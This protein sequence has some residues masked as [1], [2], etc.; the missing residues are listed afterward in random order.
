MDRRN[1]DMRTQRGITLIEILLWSVVVAATVVAVFAFAKRVRVAAAVETEQRQV[2]QVVKTVNGLFALQPNFSALGEDGAAYL[3]ARGATRMG[4]KLSP[5][6]AGAPALTTGLGDGQLNLSVWH[7]TQPSGPTIANGGYRLAYQGLSANECVRLTSALAFN[8]HQASVG[9]HGLED[10]SATVVAHRY[11]KRL[12][13]ADVVANLCARPDPVVFLYFA[14]ARS[15]SAN[16]VGPVGPPSP[17]C[18]P[19]HE[20]QYAAC[21]PGQIGTVIQ[22]RDG[23]CTGPGNTL[24]WTAWSTTDSS[25]QTPT[26]ITPPITPSLPPDDCTVITTTRVQ[27]CPAGQTGQILEESARDTC[28]GTQ[29]A[30]L[31]LPPP[32]G[33][34]CQ[35][36]LVATCVPSVE[37]DEVACPAGQGGQIVRERYSTC[38]SPQAVPAWPAWSSAHVI[39]NTCT[40]NCGVS[41]TLTFGNTCCTPI[42]DER[43]AP[44]PAGTYGPG[45]KEI[46]FQGCVNAT[47]QAS[48]WSAWEPYRDL[49]PSPGC[50]ACP[51]T[52]QETEQQWDPRAETCPT[53]QTGSITYEAEQVRTRDVSYSCP[54]GTTALPSPAIGTW[55]GWADTGARRNTVNTCVATP[56]AAGCQSGQIGSDVLSAANWW[57]PGYNSSASDWALNRP[58][59]FGVD[60]IYIAT[61]ND[62]PKTT[63]DDGGGTVVTG[64]Q[65]MPKASWSTCGLPAADPMVE[66]GDYWHAT[67][68]QRLAGTPL[69][70]ECGT[71]TPPIQCD[72]PAGKVFNWTVGGNDCTFAQG[73]A[74]SVAVSSD[75]PVTDSTAPTT[76]AAVFACSAGGVLATTPNAGA[77][78]TAPVSSCYT[79]SPTNPALLTGVWRVGLNTPVNAGP[80]GGWFW[81][82]GVGFR[83]AIQHDAARVTEY[84]NA[85]GI[86]GS[87]SFQKC[88]PS[89]FGDLTV[90]N[91]VLPNRGGNQVDA[92]RT[93]WLGWNNVTYLDANGNSTNINQSGWTEI[94]LPRL[95]TPALRCVPG[96]LI[97]T[98]SWNDFGSSTHMVL[99]CVAG[100]TQC[101]V[102]A[103]ALFNWVVG[104][105]SC[106]YTQ[107]AATTVSTSTNFAVTDST[108]PTTG[109]AAF[110]CSAGGVLSMTANA[111]ATCTTTASCTPPTGLLDG[112]WTLTSTSQI[113][114]YGGAP[115]NIETNIGDLTRRNATAASLGGAGPWTTTPFMGIGCYATNNGGSGTGVRPMAPPGGNCV[116]G[117]R[118]ASR[119]RGPSAMGGAIYSPGETF[120]FTCV[121]PPPP[122]YNG[123]CS[124]VSRPLTWGCGEI[125]L[126]SGSWVH[127]PGSVNLDESINGGWFGNGTV[128]TR[129]VF[130]YSDVLDAQGY[131]TPLTAADEGKL[132]FTNTSPSADWFNDEFLNESDGSYIGYIGFTRIYARDSAPNPVRGALCRQT[133]WEM[134]NN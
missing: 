95:A 9:F 7:V 40:A 60:D 14:P 121:A 28:A 100:P 71:A 117:E 120:F 47:T 93:T 80:G 51:A 4:L 94:W 101:D 65:T 88:I 25:C 98:R 48:T 19:I 39:S 45:G 127:T 13:G 106:T 131:P 89:V 105:N 81:D 125:R 114:P 112:V 52:V 29:T 96:E 76:G 30:W 70:A 72:I 111:G 116:I 6:A 119:V 18:N 87:A 109:S 134:M 130:G 102:P 20:K 21:P 69:P 115:G 82:D 118:I 126:V 122:A 35:T 16:G 84:M 77:T 43:D 90:F 83:G 34:T 59:L 36:P 123:L 103:G 67:S 17:R 24:V 110:A 33:N 68:Y 38:A 37:H 46:R 32:I 86:G 26:T 62:D 57:C 92:A 66:V 54:A 104:G 64:W 56:P 49:E 15:I 128:G 78:C 97:V 108:T 58:A 23:T 99:E 27:A 31:Q 53:G 55:T 85:I 11:N 50:T 5:G 41:S 133:K 63:A 10:A 113:D 8:A 44:C 3:A 79:P 73:M 42:P 129:C 132:V 107:A 124:Q 75:F 2:E 1:L 61:T 22:A 12:G 91:G 74:T